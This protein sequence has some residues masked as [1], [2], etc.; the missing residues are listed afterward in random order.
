VTQPDTATCEDSA[1]AP[2]QPKTPAR[3]FKPQPE[4]W[5]KVMADAAETDR[6]Y[7]AVI[8]EALEEYFARK[9]ED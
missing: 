5:E 1:V 9:E 8:I 7:T 2:N 3:A 6:T 4:L